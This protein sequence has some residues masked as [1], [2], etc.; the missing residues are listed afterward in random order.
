MQTAVQKI[1]SKIMFLPARP[2]FMIDKDVAQAYEITTNKLNRAANRNP[3]RFPDDFR[4]Q[5]TK[6][7][8]SH[9]NLK[10]QSGTSSWGG[11][12][13]PTLAYT[14]EGCHMV[15]TVLNTPRAVEH[16][17]MI[18]RAFSA[19]DRLKED[20]H[21]ESAYLQMLI[22]MNKRLDRI[23]EKIDSK[24]YQRPH[25]K[26]VPLF[27]ERPGAPEI[28]KPSKQLRTKSRLARLGLENEVRFLLEAER[29]YTEIAGILAEMGIATSTSAV[30]R[31]AA[32]LMKK[33]AKKSYEVQ[34]FIVHLRENKNMTYSEIAEQ[35]KT[36]R[37]RIHQIYTK[38]TANT[39]ITARIK[40]L[41][42][43]RNEKVKDFA[44]RIGCKYQLVL[45]VIAQRSNKHTIRVAIAKGLGLPY[46][47]LW[48]E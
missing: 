43:K 15:A 41:L 6:K 32:Y 11:R 46:S 44:Q 19:L 5:L 20:A 45:A 3:E 30:Q 18:I 25:G 13:K 36:S 37:Q 7:E 21:K 40:Y 33:P 16:S 29:S 42:A 31:Y 22:L 12:R 8:E 4:F 24:T 34:E 9:L 14:R 17:I 35:M 2:P 1:Q 47:E 48:G 38:T 23:E 39:E 10:F 27:G 28:K 26:V